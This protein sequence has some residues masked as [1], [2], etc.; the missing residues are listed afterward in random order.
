MKSL[1]RLSTAIKSIVFYGL[2]HVSQVCQAADKEQVIDT[3]KKSTTY[4][5]DVVSL[6]GGFLQR[7]AAD[8]SERWG[9]LPARE[10]MIWVE[11]AAT[12]GVGDVLLKAYQAS[13]DEFFLAGAKKSAAALM[14]GQYPSGGWH[15]FIDFDPQGTLQWYEEVG[16]RGWGFEEHNH[17]Y[18]NCT[19]DDQVTTAPARFLMALYFATLEPEYKAAVLRALDFVVKAQYPNGGWPQRYPPAPDHFGKEYPDYTT[20]YTF[21]DGVIEGNID[22]LLDAYEK[23]GNEQYKEAA[24]RGMDFVVMSQAEP[25]QAGW[26]LQYNMQLQSAKARSFEPAALTPLQTLSCIYSLMKYYK[27]TGDRK[28][29]GGIADAI[30]WLADSTYPEFKKTGAGNSH[31]MFYELTT[32]KAIYAHREGTNA[33]DG[34]YWIDS[35]RGNFP[36]HYGMELRID[37]ENI[38]KEYQRIYA[39]S[40]NA[41][42]AE[43]RNEKALAKSS[44]PQVSKATIDKII[45][46]MDEQG[47][48][49]EDLSIDE[50]G[51]DTVKGPKRRIKGIATYT[52]MRYI[53]QMTNY[54]QYLDVRE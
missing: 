33:E 44:V 43:Y 46:A 9:E 47:R 10:S 32:N 45:G 1:S 48:W 37:L 38:E 23:F 42:V 18:G 5:V 17:Y 8:L 19:F 52:Y 30:K 54:L 2:M 28:Y 35:Y 12:V 34:R 20:Y 15:Y 26:G 16:R 40:P 7:Y 31:A 36:I 22:L 6:K 27:I 29:L 4:M 41:A 21:N 51:G 14:A 3:M 50:Y 49:I 24:G 39:L 53:Q 13:G 25:P 11:G